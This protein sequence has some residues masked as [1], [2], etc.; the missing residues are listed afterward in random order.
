MASAIRDVGNNRMQSFVGCSGWYY[1]HWRGRFYPPKLPKSRWLSYYVARFPTVELNNTFYRLPTE[2]AIAT[3]TK[4]AAPGFLFAVKGSRYVTHVLRLHDT[5]SSVEVFCER[6]QAL[7]PHLG[8]VLWQL[9]PSL[10]RDDALL[11]DFLAVLPTKLAHTVEFRHSSWWTDS[12]Y[13]LLHNHGI[14]FCLYSMESTSTPL[15]NT[16]DFTYMRFHGPAS[17]YG[18]R[19]DDASLEQWAS[20]LHRLD[21]SVKRAFVYFNNDANAYAVE[22]AIWLRTLLD[23][24]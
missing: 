18:G 21:G 12:V 7:A 24:P 10:R 19:Y 9:P 2:S 1:Q 13:A 22:N 5:A 3:W 4:Q 16:A 20:L 6:L 15:I 17:Q 8:P 11:E 14:A 23:A